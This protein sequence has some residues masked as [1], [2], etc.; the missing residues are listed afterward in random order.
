MNREL[1]AKELLAVAKDLMAS[2]PMELVDALRL[3]FRYEPSESNRHYAVFTWRKSGRNTGRALDE[4]LAMLDRAGV[5]YK[6]R[7]VETQEDGR[8]VKL[9]IYLG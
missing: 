2:Q 1:V 6:A 5:A 3:G 4:A 9:Q 8:D 7:D